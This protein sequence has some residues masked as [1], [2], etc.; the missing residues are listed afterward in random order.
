MFTDRVVLSLHAGDGGNGVVAWRREKFIPKGGPA[1]GDGG[2]GASIIFVADAS[3]F[4]LEHLRNRRIIKAQRG[5]DGSGNNCTGKDGEDLLIKLPLGTLVKDA[6]SGEILYDF[7]HPGERWEICAG[8]KGGKGNTRFKSSTHQAPLMATPGQKGESVEV[9][10]ELKLIADVGLVGMPNAGKSMLISQLAH[11]SVKIA[12]YPFTT[13]RPNLGMMIFQDQTRLLLAD[14]PGIIEGAHRGRGC[15]FSFLRHIERSAML[16]FVIELSPWEEHRD[17]YEEFCLL[18]DELKQ[19]HPALLDRPFLVVLN[20]IDL[21]GAAVLAQAFRQRYP[22]P[23]ETLFEISAL[24]GSGCEELKRTLRM[25]KREPLPQLS[26][27]HNGEVLD[28]SSLI[29]AT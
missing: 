5:G 6:S 11:V 18:R 15:G 1:G 24:Q 17:P 7:T 20:K 13:L 8:G 16:L 26:K 27:Q 22:F 4:S 28:L 23:Q 19:Y 21:E 29:F 14:I 25:H 10:L 12:P 3:H 2:R 9:E